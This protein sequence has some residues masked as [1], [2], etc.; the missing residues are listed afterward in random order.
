MSIAISRRDLLKL[1]SSSV[2]L[3]S[4]L[5]LPTTP[6]SYDV[7]WLHLEGA[8]FRALFD[9]WPSFTQNI[10]L[11]GVERTKVSIDGRELLLPKIW[12]QTQGSD[13][14]LN[15]WL[16]IRGITTKSPHLT[17]CR[18]EWFG[19]IGNDSANEKKSRSFE[20][21]QRMKTINEVIAEWS[22]PSG[23]K[24]LKQHRKV[25][26]FII[27][28]YKQLTFES[29]KEL[30]A[31]TTTFYNSFYRD[32]IRELSSF[33]TDLKKQQLFDKSVI[34]ITSD[35][36]KA[37]TSTALPT[38]MEP[39]WQGSPLSLI[40][41]SILGPVNIGNIYKEHPKYSQAYPGTWGTP[42]MEWTP[43]DVIQL[44]SDLLHPKEFRLKNTKEK[45]KENPWISPRPLQ[46]F[47]VKLPPGR[48]V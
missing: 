21:P 24:E 36:A 23:K 10:P 45:Y 33:V 34:I 30:N 18:K 43:K 2:A 26:P 22:N 8:P 44:A 15:H 27:N 16:S 37:P 6:N 9:F 25:R 7:Y 19:G 12:E 20:A 1:I 11:P 38:P 14:I 41:G 13:S 32:I 4:C 29:M 35:R 39:V 42:E 5:N 31:E 17:Q 28:S 48:I 46:G 3:S 47:F 40:S